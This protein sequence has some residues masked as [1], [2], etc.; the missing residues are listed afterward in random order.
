MFVSCQLS[1]SVLST[2]ESTLML[3]LRGR[4]SLPN[5]VSPAASVT[6]HERHQRTAHEDRSLLFNTFFRDEIIPEIQRHIRKQPGT[7]RKSIGEAAP[8]DIMF[9]VALTERTMTFAGATF[10]PQSIGNFAC[11][12]GDSGFRC[13]PRFASYFESLLLKL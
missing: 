2:A 8:S 9:R 11:G 7:S 3:N 4:E 6:T 1:V 10:D 12:A 13:S 5:R